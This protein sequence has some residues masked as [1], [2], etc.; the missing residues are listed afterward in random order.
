MSSFLKTLKMQPSN[1]PEFIRVISGDWLARMS[2]PASVPLTIAALYIEGPW[3]KAGLIVLAFICAWYAA[4]RVWA[5]ERNKL[6]TE[7]ERAE[8]LQERLDAINSD[9]ERRRQT[10]SFP[11]RVR[12]RSFQ[13]INEDSPGT[14]PAG[15]PRDSKIKGQF[16]IENIGQS[17]CRIVEILCRPYWFEHGLPMRRPYDG[18]IGTAFSNAALKQGE[19]QPI[20]IPEPFLEQ[21]LAPRYFRNLQGQEKDIFN[22][23]FNDETGLRFFL[24]GF[25]AIEDELGEKKPLYRFCREYRSPDEGGPRRFFPVTDRDY[26]SE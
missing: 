24:M 6:V 16:I 11:P 26:E 8:K 12:A 9:N 25:V 5:A 4:Y 1:F 3:A 13:V 2:G 10:Q 7:R 23:A 14:E 17:P 18:Q 15:I 20:L 22:S 21:D 19:T